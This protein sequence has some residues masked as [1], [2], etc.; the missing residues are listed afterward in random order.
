MD[1]LHVDHGASAR[2]DEWF[3]ADMEVWLHRKIQGYLGCK[4]GEPGGR[5]IAIR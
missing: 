5:G 1:N 3:V 2:R 4:G